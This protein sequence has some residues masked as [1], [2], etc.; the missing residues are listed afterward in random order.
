MQVPLQITFRNMAPSP[1]IET[2]VR[3]Q[4]ERLEKFNG[5]ITSCRVVVEAPHRHHQKGNQFH[6]KVDVIVPGGEIVAT[7][8][9]T[10]DQSHADCYIAIRDA[11]EAAVRQLEDHSR[12]VRGRVKTHDLSQ[13]PGRVSRL[14]RDDGYGFIETADGLDVYFHE[15]SVVDGFEK[16]K[17]GTEVRF[18]L[19]DGEG[20]KGPQAST[21]SLVGKQRSTRQSIE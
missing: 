17:Q 8:E 18:Y 5:R 1:S 10:Q 16:L 3:E 11:F 21:V 13:Q 19:A 15:N 6:V 2:R 4:A 12:R 7:R 20:E 14:F 9:P